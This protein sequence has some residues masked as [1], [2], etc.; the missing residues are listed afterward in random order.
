M[1]VL[2]LAPGAVRDE[3]DEPE[4]NVNDDEFGEFV[5]NTLFPESHY[6]LVKKTRNYSN[7][8]EEFFGSMREPDLKFQSRRNGREFYVEVK[9]CSMFHNGVIDWCQ[10]LQLKRY[11][12]LH[13]RVPVYIVVG[14]GGQ[15]GAPYQISLIPMEDLGLIRLYP[16]I[17]KEY[18][19]SKDCRITEEKL[20]MVS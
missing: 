19:V 10:P 7:G 3:V 5:R 15:P 14:I 11:Q 16:S 13:A 4:S 17:L 6:I 9:Y 8:E 18:R 12:T 2:T 1:S 20:L